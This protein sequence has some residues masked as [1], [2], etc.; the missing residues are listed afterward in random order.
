M[1][2]LDSPGCG[3]CGAPTGWTA[4]ESRVIRDVLTGSKVQTRIKVESESNRKTRNDS[5][6]EMGH[7]GPSV[8]VRSGEESTFHDICEG[9]GTSGTSGL[10]KAC[11]C[12]GPRSMGKSSA[13]RI[14][15]MGWACWI[16][17]L[18]LMCAAAE[19][20]TCFVNTDEGVVGWWQWHGEGGSS[21]MWR[22]GR[23]RGPTAR[24]CGRGAR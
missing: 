4:T 6:V 13:L 9:Y 19:A 17:F 15:W 14:F 10:A 11:T 3:E 12:G 2:V 21:G 24:Q 5:K 8:T 16:M 18:P 22:V 23:R 7:W 1:V 20:D